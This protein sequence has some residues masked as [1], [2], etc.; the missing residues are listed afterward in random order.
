MSISRFVGAS[1]G[2]IG[3]ND[4]NTVFESLKFYPN[5]IIVFDNIDEAHISI[6]NLIKSI[7]ENGKLTNSKGN[8]LNFSNSF[9][10]LTRNINNEKKIG[11]S[12]SQNN[13]NKTMSCSDI[14]EFVNKIVKIE[15][16]KKEK[17]PSLI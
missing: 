14:D 5:S 12:N 9:I 10:I 2:Y 17:E 8:V 16:V 3:Y 6:I 13:V 11:F 7:L 1:S 4:N 15:N